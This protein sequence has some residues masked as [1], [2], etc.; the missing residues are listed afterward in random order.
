MSDQT[1]ERLTYYQKNRQTMLDNAKRYRQ[2]YPEKVKADQAAYYQKVVGPRKKLERKLALI[3]AG[4]WPPQPKKR[5]VGEVKKRTK[6][7]KNFPDISTLAHIPKMPA[8]SGRVER[9]PGIEFD[10]NNL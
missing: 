6:R 9:L 2:Q 1:S 8:S 5:F 7:L 3:E 4:N 10:W